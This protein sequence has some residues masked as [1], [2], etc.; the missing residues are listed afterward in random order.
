MKK[1]LIVSFSGGAT[2]AF[3]AR[4]CQITYAKTHDI[5]YLFANTGEEHEKTLEFVNR[6]DKEWGLNVVWVEAL[7]NPEKGKGT[8]HKVV[9]FETA[10]RLGEP[11][12]DAISKYGIFNKAY[13]HC[14]RET[15]L[16]PMESYRKSI[17]WNKKNSEVAIGIRADEADR[18]S[19]KPKFYNLIYPLAHTFPVSKEMIKAWWATQ[20]FSL[21]IPEHHGNC[22]TCWKKS[23]RKLKT[24]AIENP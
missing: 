2:S 15:K 6:C 8:R 21:G 13:S 5:V 10:S 16:A 23:D 7:V 20:D 22:K 19:A 4:W 14:N 17:G 1:K 9:T 11:L 12:E 18:C 24:I 3:M